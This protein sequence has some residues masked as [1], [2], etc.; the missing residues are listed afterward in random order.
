MICSDSAQAQK[1]AM[2]GRPV[3]SDEQLRVCYS[4]TRGPPAAL[5]SFRAAVGE[6]HHSYFE[7]ALRRHLF[8]GEAAVG[9]P[10]SSLP[11]L[12]VPQ[13]SALQINAQLSGA[14]DDPSH[15][16]KEEHA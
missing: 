3:L 14:K 15:Q 4:A 2:K 5:E 16:N 7:E 13:A 1:A 9:T 11:D 12:S 10:L 8:A 6:K